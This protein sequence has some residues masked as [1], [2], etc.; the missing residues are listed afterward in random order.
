MSP[1]DFQPTLVGPRVI[2]RP[3]AASDWAQLYAA[4]ADPLIWELHPVPD[5]YKESVFREFFNSALASQSSFTFVNRRTEAIVGSSRYNGY[6]PDKR[7]IEIG[8]TFLTREYWGAGYNGEIKRMMLDHAFNYVDA[9]FFLVGELNLRSRRA[10]EKLGGVLQPGA[11][12]R[13]M[14]G[15]IH[16]HLIYEIRKSAWIAA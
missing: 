5:R 3:L 6:D 10:M 12:E 11:I 2:I 16:R 4:A 1:F 13:M 7:E 8:W 9:V 14:S 15:Q